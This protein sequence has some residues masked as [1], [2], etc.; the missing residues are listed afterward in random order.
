MTTPIPLHSGIR[1]YA[2][3]PIF[4]VILALAFIRT[5]LLGIL[6]DA[7]KVK[8]SE[9]K[10]NNIISRCKRLVQGCGIL[11]DEAWNGRCGYFLAKDT[12]ALDKYRPSAKDPMDAMQGMSDPSQAMG[13]MKSQMV[14]IFSQGATGYWVNHLFSGF[15]VAKTP[16]PLTFR[17][18]PMMQRGVAVDA[19]DVS[20]ISSLS[21]YFIVMICSSGLQQL[22]SSWSSSKAIDPN[23]TNE[24]MMQNMMPMGAAAGGNPMM[25]GPDPAKAYDD[26]K[27]SMKLVS[28]KWILH[29]SEL[30]LMEQWKKGQ[31]FVPIKNG[32]HM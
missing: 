13:M 31:C 30:K 3:I 32:G 2:L 9:M 16:F 24:A 18:K 17:F 20:Y 10:Q 28:H 25:G 7:P 11:S 21:W 23:S 26:A 4:L 12:G 29:N 14:F 5:K 22:L 27:E 8:I 15:L 1:D 6:K 19:L